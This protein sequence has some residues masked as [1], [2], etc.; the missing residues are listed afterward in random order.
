MSAGE[1][2][3]AVREAVELGQHER[4][5]VPRDEHRR[6]VDDV[7]ARR[8]QVHV[9]GRVGPDR[10]SELADERLGRVPD[11]AAVVCDARRVEAIGTARL[12]DPR[13]R[14]RRD[15]ADC[16]ARLRKGVLRIEHSL[17]P[18]SIRDCV[19]QLLSARRSLRT[20]SHREERRLAGALEDDVEAKRAVLCACDEGRPLLGLEP[21]EH[22]IL[23]VRRLLVGEVHARRDALEEAASEDPHEKV[24]R[25]Q[26][27]VEPTAPDRASR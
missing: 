26:P 14:V 11:C 9:L 1:L 15:E 10:S 24:R 8:S 19:S 2:R 17:Q 3:A 27:A 12:P 6:R 21:E 5:G 4:G 22:G 25:L 18:R 16:D 7:L 23:G 20:E 13:G